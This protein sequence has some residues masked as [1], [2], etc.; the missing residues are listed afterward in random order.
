[1]PEKKTLT[2]PDDAHKRATAL[3]R[4]YVSEQWEDEIGDLKAGLLLDFILTEVGPTIYTQA[5]ADARAFFEER[6]TDLAA[7]CYHEEFPSAGRRR[8]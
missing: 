1:M 6:A 4:A 2:I 8:P 5:I 3:L 7:L